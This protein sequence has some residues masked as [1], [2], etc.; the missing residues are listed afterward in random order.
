MK[1]A[2]NYDEVAEQL[3]CDKKLIRQ[4][5]ADGELIAFTVS[6]HPEARTLRISH[7]ELTR[8]I[9]ARE[10]AQRQKL[11]RITAMS[12]PQAQGE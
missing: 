6:S 9:A 5:V 4:L 8:F 11:A 10:D 12:K 2:Y 7:S 1:L 3:G